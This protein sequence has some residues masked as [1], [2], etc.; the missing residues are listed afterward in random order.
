[1]ADLVIS[2]DSVTLHLSGAEKVEA[3]RRDLTVSRS[4]IL[5][6]R[7]V[8]SCLDE[9]PGFKLL[10]SDVPGELKVGMWKRAD[11]GSTFAACHGNGPGL[12]ID[13]TGEHYD[14]IVLTLDNPEQ[15]AAALS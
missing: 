14:R 1:V 6:V 10:G 8:S 13:L 15:I 4:A 3:L 7:V 12:V 11:G 2:S 9:V 5:G